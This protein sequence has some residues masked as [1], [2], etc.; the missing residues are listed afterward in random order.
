M[1][2]KQLPDHSGPNVNAFVKENTKKARFFV[3]ECLGI[4][5]TELLRHAGWNVDDVW[6]TGLCGQPDENLFAFAQKQDRILLTHNV[7]F[8]DDRK[9]PPD[10]NR[11]P[12]VIV[13]PGASGGDSILIRA[14]GQALSIVGRFREIYRGLKVV[15]SEDGILTLSG[16]NLETGKIE[17]TRYCFPKNRMTQVWVD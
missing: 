16:R 12:G 1:P 15:V 11:N 9:F 4:G 6:E 7:D 17:R 13:L 3:D 2:W 5:V 14:I 10:Q 8:L